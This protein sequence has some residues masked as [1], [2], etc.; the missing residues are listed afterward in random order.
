[1]QVHLEDAQLTLGALLRR[2]AQ[3]VPSRTAIVWE[4][5]R[6]TF[7][8]L[9]EAVNRVA[10]GFRAAGIKP[11]DPIGLLINKRPELVVTFLA[12]A[13]MGAI[14]TPINYK[15]THDRIRFQFEHIGMTACI[16]E[17]D[18]K[19][20]Y[21]AVSELMPDP[22]RAIF[23]S[24]PP[25]DLHNTWAEVMAHSPE[26]PP[27]TA[28]PDDVVYLNYTSGSTGRPK[29][30]VT[31]HA[32]IQWNCLS[33]LATFPMFEDDV[34]LGMFSTFSHPHELF[35]RSIYLGCTA[36]LCDSL[37]P[38]IVAKAI[39]EH[40]VTWM[41]AVPSFYEMLFHQ[42]ESGNVDLSSLRMLEAGGA[43]IDAQTLL[44]MEA[45]FKTKLM[46]VWGSTETSGV[47]LALL[48]DEGR[49][50]GT[51]GK[52]CAFYEFEVMDESDQ[53]VGPDAVGELVVRGPAVV[54]GYLNMEEENRKFFRDGWYH[55]QDLVSRDADG[56]FRFVARRSEML[57]IGGIRVYP[58]EIEQAIRAHADVQNVVV[59]GASDRL[60][61]EMARAI[62]VRKPDS[63]LTEKVLRAHCRKTLAVYQVPRIIEFW[64]QLPQLPNGKID[65]KTI[66]ETPVPAGHDG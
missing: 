11:G 19:A 54:S 3:R 10:N 53:P 60:R 25:S 44:E 63:G 38:R 8:A 51:I 48:P 56:F 21:D 35:H 41:M 64:E 22:R 65:K 12:C 30:A 14:A 32:N 58:V 52:A 23:L 4:D 34:F 33:N 7:A 57:K 20:I 46:P 15:L 47:G 28:K 40:R 29:G 17:S 24:N 18:H 1:M 61:G 5:Q 55:T 2:T 43:F 9:D 49:K 6:I 27:Y 31:T 62:V 26:D 66:M 36:V 50:P 13:R 45:R 42:A 16:I 39:Q 37:S 59:V